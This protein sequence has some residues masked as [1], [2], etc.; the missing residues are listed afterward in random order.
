MTEQ[1]N[2]TQRKAGLSKSQQNRIDYE[3]FEE[4]KNRKNVTDREIAKVQATSVALYVG[5]KVGKSV[6]NSMMRNAELEVNLNNAAVSQ[7]GSVNGGV[8]TGIGSIV[9]GRKIVKE[10]LG[11]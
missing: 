8:T 5:Y 4:G 7:Y 6:V 2:Q 10:M 1:H 9:R 11:I 3:V